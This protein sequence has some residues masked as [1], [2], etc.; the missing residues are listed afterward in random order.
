MVVASG[1]ASGAARVGGIN[2]ERRRGFARSGQDYDFGCQCA[3][4]YRESAGGKPNIFG[5]DARV[6]GARAMDTVAANCDE[7]FYFADC[8]V[9]D[10]HA[11]AGVF[12]DFIAGGAGGRRTDLDF[13]GMFATEGDS[14]G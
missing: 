5:A 1:R 8:V 13:D 10:G 7:Q 12:R 4:P 14:R 9:F 3:L 11:R 6:Y 2:S